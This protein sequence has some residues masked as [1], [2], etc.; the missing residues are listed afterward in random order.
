MSRVLKPS[1][2]RPSH[3][4][5]NSAELGHSSAT[6]QDFISTLR[7]ST[8][9]CIRSLSCSAV[10]K[11]ASRSCLK[12]G[13]SIRVNQIFER[14]SDYSK[15]VHPICHLQRVKDMVDRPP[16]WMDIFEL[17]SLRIR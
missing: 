13:K 14:S 8:A 16:E 11:E 1:L 10:V 3:E 9:T 15:H 5:R 12:A 4:R 7:C 17:E 6:Q 2:N